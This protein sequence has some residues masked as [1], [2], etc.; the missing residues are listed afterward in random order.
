MLTKRFTD[1]DER[2]L[3]DEFDEPQKKAICCNET[4]VLLGIFGDFE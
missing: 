3:R 2:F 4:A 1:L